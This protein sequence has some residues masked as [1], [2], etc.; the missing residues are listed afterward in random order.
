MCSLCSADERELVAARRDHRNFAAT[1]DRLANAYRQMADGALNPHDPPRL[2][3]T[4]Q[5]VRTAIVRL[6]G[7]WL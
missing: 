5:D 1:L 3:V 2:V 7:D 6:S 4:E